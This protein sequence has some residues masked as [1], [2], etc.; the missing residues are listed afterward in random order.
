MMSGHKVDI[1]AFGAHP[2][3]VE[4]AVG[5]TILKH[6]AMG[7]TVAIV[8]LTA[9]ELGSYGTPQTRKVEAQAAATLL[10][11]SFREQLGLPDG[12]VVNSEAQRMIVIAAIRKYQPD[13]VLANAVHDRHPDHAASAQLVA[14]AC[15]LSGLQKIHTMG[16]N[17]RA[18]Q[19]WRPK[20]VYHYIQDYLIEP[21]FVIDITAEMDAKMQAILAFTSQFV[22]PNDKQ[23]GSILGLLNQIKSTNSIF[24][25]PINVAY[26]EGFT[27]TRYI[28]V[29][30]LYDLQ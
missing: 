1:M 8:D 15:F 2:D 24:G 29:Q 11:V 28:G 14:D 26:A 23:P 19:A 5:G 12:G 27:A 9:G 21:D 4:C 18:Q 13:I 22:E 16:D 3:D 25:R 17:S 10:G 20:A 7:K 6:T 30:N